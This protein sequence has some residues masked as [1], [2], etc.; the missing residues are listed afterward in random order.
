MPKFIKLAF[1][2]VGFL[3]LGWAI[4][5]VDM[6]GVL[7]LLKKLG[8]GFLIIL[9][10]YTGVTWLDTLSWKCNF[11]P[12]ETGHFTDWEL[13]RIRQ[14]GEAYN[15]ITPFATL[16][17]EPI[18]AQLLKE[19]QG[20]SLKQ[21]LSSQV[22][23]KTTFLMGLIIF[24]IPGI[25]MILISPKVSE[26]FKTIS[27]VGMGAFSTCIFLF[28]VFQVTGT[29]G[30]LCIWLNQRTSRP[31][32]INFLVQLEHLNELFS[33]FYEKYPV[34]VIKA[35]VLAFLGWVLG[36]GEMYAILY[37]LGFPVSFY[38]LWV[39]EALA[40]LVK[41]GSFMIPMSLGAQEGGLILIFRALGYPANLGLAVS[42]VA[43]TKQLI[44][45]GLGLA[46]G[47]QMAF[48]PTTRRGAN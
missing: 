41:I 5:A 44:W 9:M 43:R 39:M 24:F 8:G 34:R 48:K 35:V 32:L 47:G 2:I 11:C 12:E 7:N 16:G 15:Y 10:I 13:W 45:V 23:A 21:G 4:S 29:L 31:N 28:F 42:L 36:L 25:A 6:A 3:F 22:I 19:N 37:F 17:G 46:L 27:I 20:L 33:G 30:K 26:E 14:I 38:D 1:L 18:K 40:Q